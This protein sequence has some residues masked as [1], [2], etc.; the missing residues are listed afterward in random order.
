MILINFF[1]IFIII[2]KSPFR[3]KT[4]SLLL[5]Y[6]SI[7]LFFTSA[8]SQTTHKIS[9]NY[10]LFIEAQTGNPYLI[11]NDSIL[12][13]NFDFNNPIYTS[14]P[15]DIVLNDF[16]QYKYKIQDENYFVERGGGRVL[17]FKNDS[18]KRID[19]SFSHRN[20]YGAVPFVNNNEMFLW[21]GYGL[22]TFKNILTKY[23]LDNNEWEAVYQK[24]PASITEREGAYHLKIDDTLFV[25]GGRINSSNHFERVIKGNNLLHIMDLNKNEWVKSNLFINPELSFL[26]SKQN[27][28]K[29]SF[30]IGNSL[31]IKKLEKI[32]KIDLHNNK[33]HTY[34]PNGQLRS[35]LD[36]VYSNKNNEVAYIF[37][38][39]D[40]IFINKCS[41][42]EFIGDKIDEVPFLIKKEQ[43]FSF[44]LV[45]FLPL[46]VFIGYVFFVR[47]TKP[48]YSKQQ[49]VINKDNSSIF[50]KNR[51]LDVF[52][53]KQLELLLFLLH[54]NSQ[55]I[56][57]TRVNKIFTETPNDSY[58][59]IIKRRELAIKEL[60]IKLATILKIKE[61]EVL[62]YKK[63]PIDKRIRLIKINADVSI[64]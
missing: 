32:F 30:Q 31:L 18:L 53:N 50:I 16:N 23:N 15:K 45:G 44:Y 29:E 56:E 24:N 62:L 9:S 17:H 19:N 27:F 48:N 21:G 34:L 42:N 12:I 28:T 14:L 3:M 47:K 26:S 41:L 5:C 51:K 37:K 8:F 35:V 43:D 63:S 4:Y 61:S 13:K 39:D 36:F 58:S 7:T 40:L 10:L 55:F 6:L 64:K 11:Y 60:K 59:T 22:F 49:F 38:K 25:F 1:D 46:I 2:P 57:L 33:L 54:N 52:Q 20:Q